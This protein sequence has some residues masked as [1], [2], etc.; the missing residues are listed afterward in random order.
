MR[1]VVEK[2]IP[3]ITQAVM[4]LQKHVDA[5]KKISPA[6][7]KRV[8]QSLSVVFAELQQADATGK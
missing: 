3:E 4:L 2:T 7:K 6:R 5:S 1:P 8:K